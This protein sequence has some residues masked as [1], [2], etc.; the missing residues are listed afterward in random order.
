MQEFLDWYADRRLRRSGRP[1]SPVTLNNKRKRVAQ[2]STLTG[3]FDNLVEALKDPE[4]I[5][6]VLDELGKTNSPGSLRVVW[7][8]LGDLS[9]WATE[10]GLIPASVM[11]QVERPGH[12]PPPSIDTYTVEEMESFKYASFARDL[13]YGVFIN[14]LAET[15]R[16]VGETLSLEWEWF[17]MLDDPPYIRLPY[18]KGG[19]P[20]YI[21]LTPRLREHVFTARNLARMREQPLGVNG[22]PFT[23][24]P[25]VYPFPWTYANAYERFDTLCRHLDITNRGFHNFRHTVITNRLAAGMPM[26]AVSALAGHASTAVT[27]ARYNHT[28]A[29]SFAHLLEEEEYR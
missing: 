20:Q 6:A 17:R 2:M 22:Q 14:F 10:Q 26:Q 5:Q 1:A 16:R 19:T 13:R 25:D 28:N 18:N 3:G 12:N 7:F 9:D 24:D 27:D 29:L 11:S 8:V 23:R 15:G 21:P 4:D